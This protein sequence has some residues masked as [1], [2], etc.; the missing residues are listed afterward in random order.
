M[1]AS[2][3]P[4][5]PT[6]PAER[7]LFTPNR[8]FCPGPTPSPWNTKQAA[9]DSDIYHRSKEFESLVLD[10]QSMLKPVFGTSTQP[11]LLTCSGTGAMESVVAHLTDANDQVMVVV[12]GK[13][14][15]RWKNLNT[16]YGNLVHEISVPLGQAPTAADVERAFA[17]VHQPKVFFIQANETSTG[18]RYDIHGLSRLIKSISPETLIAVDAISS[19]G[20]HPMDMDL[21]G[22]DAAV[23]GSQKGFGVAPGLSFVALS[24]RAWSL[25]SQRAK[26]YFDLERERKGQ[27]SGRT[28]W[29]PGISLIQSLHASLKEITAIGVSEI[30][31]HHARLA[32]ACQA[33][34]QAMG[35]EFFVAAD[36]RS[37]ALTT[38]KVPAGVDGV[39]L[40]ATAKTK[41]GAIISG[42][43]DELK[44]RII[45]FSHL[46]FVSPFMLIDGLACLEFALVDEGYR[47]TLGSGVSA[48]MQSLRASW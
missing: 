14:G 16:S 44:G 39:K 7:A 36:A 21:L 37:H 8:L 38:L 34:A 25:K 42:G 17:T 22:I 12:G 23:S 45:R 28:A 24:P 48:A 46:G 26:F 47:F 2:D 20:A 43:Q 13:F 15:E 10:C 29:T 5:K 31:R 30:F 41:Y 3:H 9:L 33:A 1:Y 40:L 4:L 11:V 19:L 35:L 32:K 6:S 27:E 18:A